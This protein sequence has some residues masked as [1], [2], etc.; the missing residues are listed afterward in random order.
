MCQ[1]RRRGRR[2]RQQFGEEFA[3]RL[4]LTASPRH[5]F[6]CRTAAFHHPALPFLP[7]LHVADGSGHRR[8]LHPRNVAESARIADY[9]RSLVRIA[10]EGHPAGVVHPVAA[11][12]L[13]G[14]ATEMEIAVE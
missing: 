1:H 4:L 13:L 8:Q 2:R 5:R 14:H 12:G 10:A 9:C 11:S 7:V 3:A 6:G